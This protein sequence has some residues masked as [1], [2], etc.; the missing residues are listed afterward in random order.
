[1]TAKQLLFLKTVL[2][3]I[4]VPSV[5]FFLKVGYE[6][7][8]FIYDTLCEGAVISNENQVFATK[9]SHNKV[10]PEIHTPIIPLEAMILYLEKQ[11][12]SPPPSSHQNFEDSFIGLNFN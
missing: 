9:V 8:G 1:M 5:V 6:D 3:F 11:K 2:I 7:P 10:L 12:N 4:I